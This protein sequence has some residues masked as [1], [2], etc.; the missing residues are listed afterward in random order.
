VRAPDG[1]P[2]FDLEGRLP[3]RGAWVCPVPACVDGLAPGALARAL[4]APVTLPS[5]AERRRALAAALER[6]VANLAEIGRAH[7]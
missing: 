5:L 1:A 6:R 4:R 2:C 7:V 3:G